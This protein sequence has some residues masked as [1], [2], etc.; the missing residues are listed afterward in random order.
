MRGRYEA[1]AHAAGVAVHGDAFD[2][3]A[4]RSRWLAR[5]MT[6][7]PAVLAH[8]L[9]E[10]PTK[11]AEALHSEAL[12][13]PRRGF[14]GALRR[15]KHGEV[16]RI[17]WRETTT[18]DLETAMTELSDLAAACIDAALAAATGELQVRFG[19]RPCAPVVIGMGKLGSRELNL[20]SDVDLIFAYEADRD[21]GTFPW[22]R[23]LFE[24]VTRMLSEVTPDGFVHRVDLGLRP[25]GRTGPICN[26]LPALERYYEAWGHAWERVAWLR[27]RPVAGDLALGG[28][29]LSTLTPFVFRRHLDHASLGEIRT[30][31]AEIDRLAHTRPERDVKLGPGGIRE[32]EFFAQ[33]LQLV[34]GGAMPALRDRSTL[35]ALNRLVHAG[36]VPA[37]DGAALGDAYLFLRAVEHQLQLLDD[38]QTQ[39]LPEG[40]DLDRVALGLGLAGTNELLAELARHR[41][42]VARLWRQLFEGEAAGTASNDVDADEVDAVL[43]GVVDD[44]TLRRLGYPAAERA[45]EHFE[46]LRRS[47]RSPLHPRAALRGRELA[48]RIV[49]EAATVADP[50]QALL[51]L[52]ELVR[53]A[54]KATWEFLEAHPPRL[55]ML[56][57][58]LGTSRFL[59]GL[60]ARDPSLLH[61]VVLSGSTAALCTREQ[62]EK[63]L[64]RRVGDDLET[65]LAHLRAAH[66]AELLRVG[67]HDVSGTLREEDVQAQLTLLAEETLKAAL[68]L[69]RA[70][71]PADGALAVVALGR[72]G[73]GEMTYGSDLDLLFLF[74]GDR[75]AHA[76]LC[77]RVVS[78]LTLGRLYEVDMR[79]RPSGSQGAL[80]VTPEALLA[81]YAGPAALHEQQALLR[82]R[83]VAGDATLSSA[84]EAAIAAVLARPRDIDAMKGEVHRVRERLRQEVAEETESTLDL[85]YG[86]GG[87]VEIDLVVQTLR[88]IDGGRTLPARALGTLEALG[89][90]EQGGHLDA[91]AAAALR[92]GYHVLRRVES[93]LRIAL[94]RPVHRV[95]MDG[96]AAALLARRMGYH[97]LPGR[98]GVAALEAAWREHAAAVRGVYEHV[99]GLNRK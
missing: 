46:A 35:G 31:K 59:G 63:T 41:S 90:L 26:S 30:M 68:A 58:L 73:A 20:S 96:P 97:D 52:R 17:V 3:V 7:D 40:E 45:A 88:L 51:L 11:T 8:V 4:P 28:E 1:A 70:E 33:A 86:R 39:E 54:G 9:A 60:L 32:V 14:E 94:D 13:V 93:R 12:E 91:A 18:R 50:D 61:H 72:L 66:Q 21:D 65:A 75:A 34:H 92:E 74:Q 98:T 48:R 10:P 81:Y 49:R 82:A 2:L 37:S 80:L 16:L 19:P 83:V 89:L 56:L 95:A 53:S 76:R 64:A 85:K 71:V 38:R 25:E 87:L 29:L 84:L 6:S 24:R 22:M 15:W 67:F 55:P 44:T 69:V 5:L 62:V 79:L 23:R 77:P 27:A 42:A 78:A 99:M 47:P 43:A 36:L 57:H